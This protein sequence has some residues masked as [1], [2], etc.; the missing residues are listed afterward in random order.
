MDGAERGDGEGSSDCKRRRR[1]IR[2]D[3]L[4]YTVEREGRVERQ[5]GR[6]EGGKEERIRRKKDQR[7]RTRT[8]KRRNDKL[9][10]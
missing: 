9:I 3:R 8:Y 4:S 6:K 1:Q 2:E 5:R 7:E 10:G